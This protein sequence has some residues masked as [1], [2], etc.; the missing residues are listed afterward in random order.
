M[1]ADEPASGLPAPDGACWVGSAPFE[2]AVAASS[3][4]V[5][6]AVLPFVVLEASMFTPGWSVDP[7]LGA[8]G[9]SLVA[10]TGQT[11]AGGSGTPG[12]RRAS[13]GPAFATTWPG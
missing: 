1:M 10:W 7:E 8:W 6:L 4:R 13:S 12:T 5:A 9:Y 3:P 11:G 2:P